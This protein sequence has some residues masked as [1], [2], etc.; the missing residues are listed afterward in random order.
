MRWVACQMILAKTLLP[1]DV[2]ECSTECTPVDHPGSCPGFNVTGCVHTYES[3]G[4]EQTGGG[5]PVTTTY[6]SVRDIV[7]WKTDDKEG[8]SLCFPKLTSKMTLTKI[9]DGPTFFTVLKGGAMYDLFEGDGVAKGIP[10]SAPGTYY[11]EVEADGIIQSTVN[12]HGNGE[13]FITKA[14]GF[15][16][17]ICDLLSS[18]THSPVEGAKIAVASRAIPSATASE[19]ELQTLP[20]HSLTSSCFFFGL[21]VLF[22]RSLSLTLFQLLHSIGAVISLSLTS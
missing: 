19:A 9:P 1:A 15:I 6:Q 14:D 16:T 11:V 22:L 5:D 4:A 10:M 20:K 7:L 18:Y 17:N 8:T 13:T 2:S 3:H 21:E 12:A